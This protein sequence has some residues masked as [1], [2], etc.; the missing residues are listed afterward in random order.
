[1]NTS[2]QDIILQTLFGFKNVSTVSFEE[3]TDYYW[4]LLQHAVFFTDLMEADHGLWVD[5]DDV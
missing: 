3:D 4:E 2:D 5:T 1:M